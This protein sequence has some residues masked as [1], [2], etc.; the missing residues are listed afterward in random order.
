[1]WFVNKI[2]NNSI[3]FVFRSKV[4]S[5]SWGHDGRQD[6]LFRADGRS[7]WPA[8]HWTHSLYQSKQESIFV[9]LLGNLNY[10]FI[11]KWATFV[12][13]S[14]QMYFKV[15]D[16]TLS[17]CCVDQHSVQVYSSTKPRIATC[18]P[19]TQQQFHIC[20]MHSWRNNCL[21]YCLFSCSEGTSLQRVLHLEFN[22][23]CSRVFWPDDALMW[24]SCLKLHS[25]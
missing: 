13:S 6:Q 24:H 19:A 5:I 14:L 1:M 8:L 21:F 10:Q 17:G 11:S 2:T 20:C 4:S 22:R 9:T 25:L 7:H 15:P 16:I 12:P 3:F 23:N 18:K